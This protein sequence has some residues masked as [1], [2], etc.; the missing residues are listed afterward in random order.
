MSSYEVVVVF[1]FG[2]CC[3][4]FVKILMEYGVVGCWV[5]CL[6]YCGV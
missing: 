3:V 5:V 6:C 2:F 4:V 1:V